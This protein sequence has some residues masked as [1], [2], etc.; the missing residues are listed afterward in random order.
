MHYTQFHVAHVKASSGSASR[1][2][3]VRFMLTA[4][5]RTAGRQHMQAMS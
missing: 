3:A 2:A 5:R 4:W 1:V